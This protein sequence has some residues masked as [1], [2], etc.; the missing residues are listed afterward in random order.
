MDGLDA[1]RQRI[2]EAYARRERDIPAD[3]YSPTRPS[4]LFAIQQRARQAL[5]ALSGAGLVPLRGRRVLEVGC[6]SRGWLPEM[7]AW[8]IDRRDLAGIDLDHDR[9]AACRRLLAGE[10]GE[11]GRLLSPGAEILEGDASALPWPAETF[12]L[13]IQSTVMSSILDANMRVEVAKESLRVLQTRGCILW[14]DFEFDNPCNPDVRGVTRR[15]IARLFPDCEIRLRRVTLAPPLSRKI[16]P[17][18][19]VGALL[20]ESL[21][22]LNTHLLGIIRKPGTGQ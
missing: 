10:R 11:S 8:G 1:E 12:D 19:W 7:E 17:V 6:G 14:Y 9:V 18:T 13:V 4:N 15:D 20:L 3:F 2:R 21:R 16:V 22:I 5:T